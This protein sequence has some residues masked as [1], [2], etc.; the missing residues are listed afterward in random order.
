MHS[1]ATLIHYFFY[2]RPKYY[3]KTKCIKDNKFNT[4]T[5]SCIKQET[6]AI[7]R[8]D[9]LNYVSAFCIGTNWWKTQSWG[10]HSL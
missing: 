2:S 6:G 3:L 10:L 1:I 8:L 7:L 9:N 4:L 5:V